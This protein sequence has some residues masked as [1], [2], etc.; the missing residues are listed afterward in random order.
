MITYPAKIT[1]SKKDKAFDVEFPDL[2]GC[3]TYG[4]TLEEALAYAKDALNGYLESID[5]RALDIPTPSRLSGKNI[6]Q[7]APDTSVGFA[8]WLKMAR[9]KK[10]LTQKQIAGMLH[11]PYQNYQNFENPRKSNPTLKNLVKIQNVLQQ[12]VL[13]G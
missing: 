3:L 6:Y 2:K 8:I 12:K 9:K 1:Y 5:L 4:E 10:H 13:V 7:I 11:I